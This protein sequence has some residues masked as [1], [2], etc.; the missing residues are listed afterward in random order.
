MQIKSGQ[1][2]FV[3]NESVEFKPIQLSSSAACIL[4]KL[5]YVGIVSGKSCF[6]DAYKII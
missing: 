5:H 2:P 4:L 1:R 6:T 3:F